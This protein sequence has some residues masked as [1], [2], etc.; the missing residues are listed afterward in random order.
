MANL[1]IGDLSDFHLDMLR[2]IENIGM[3]NAATSLSDML[4]QKIDVSVPNVDVID[5]SEVYDKIHGAENMVV[6]IIFN[7]T[8]DLEGCMLF[9]IE[10]Q[11]ALDMIKRLMM[12]DV[13]SL[14]DLDEAGISVLQEVANVMAGNFLRSLSDL[15]NFTV[16]ISIPYICVDMLGA[17]MNIPISQ[18]GM[19]GNK[20][21]LMQENILGDHCYYD[22]FLLLAPTVES[23][24]KLLDKVGSIYG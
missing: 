3:G 23:L 14:A 19:L 18:F 21:L 2:E 5:I 16:Q 11:F 15:T 10:E 7:M 12:M 13:A 4:G 8:G 6:G 17:I 24:S 22:S 20:V 1:G 9:I